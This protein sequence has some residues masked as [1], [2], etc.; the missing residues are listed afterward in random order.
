MRNFPRHE[1]DI[2]VMGQQQ[3]IQCLQA[4]G[5]KTLGQGGAA[6]RKARLRSEIGLPPG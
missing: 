4:L 5:I 6:E 2:R 3:V 1:R